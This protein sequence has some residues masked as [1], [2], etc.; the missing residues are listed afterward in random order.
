MTDFEWKDAGTYFIGLIAITLLFGLI[1]C[2]PVAGVYWIIYFCTLFKAG[3]EQAAISAYHEYLKNETSLQWA[4]RQG[5]GHFWE[6]DFFNNELEYDINNVTEE[7]V[8]ELW[9]TMDERSDRRAIRYCSIH[10]D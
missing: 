8:E 4:A 1:G 2:L 3:K 5:Y 6:K 9:R 10:R 7:I